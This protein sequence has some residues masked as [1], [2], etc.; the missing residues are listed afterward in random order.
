M[1][2][3]VALLLATV[4][5]VAPLATPDSPH[6]PDVTLS[7]STVTALR[8]LDSVVTANTD[9][10]SISIVNTLTSSVETIEVGREPT[11]VAADANRIWVTVRA[12]NEVV[13]L[14][15]TGGTWQITDRVTVG[16]EPYGIVV[17]PDGMRLY[18]AVSIDD[19]VVEL[20]A[21]T[22]EER[23]RFDVPGEPRWLALHPTG[24]TLAVMPARG[25]GTVLLNNLMDGEPTVFPMD[26]YLEPRRIAMRPSGDPSFNGDGTRLWYPLAELGSPLDTG[27]RSGDGYY[28]LPPWPLVGASLV[29]M[30]F[31]AASGAAT[32]DIDK[33]LSVGTSSVPTHIAAYGDDALYVTFEGLPDVLEF[34]PHDRRQSSQSETGQGP[35]GVAMD[36]QGDVWVH[37]PFDRT[38]TRPWLP[39][40]P[41][42][43]AE[44]VLPERVERGRNLF[45][46]STDTTM[47]A[48]RIS[49]AVCH[50]EGRSDGVTWPL[51]SGD[52]QTP[53]LGGDVDATAPVSWSQD[54]P[55]VREEARLTITGP[56]AGSEEAD[57]D[58]VAA[59]VNHVRLPNP[60]T[61][62]V[63]DEVLAV[64]RAAFETAG[65]HSCHAPPLYTDNQ[66]HQMFGLEAV[67]TPTLFG[68]AS[69]APYLHNGKAASLDDLLD[70]S[71]GH[72]GQPEVLSDEE[73]A[74][75]VAWLRTL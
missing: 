5:C 55:S 34:H 31:S 15:R 19:Q 22:L 12:D 56:M 4:G 27:R 41:I 74:A 42:V 16:S 71:E 14:E 2:V 65:C 67:Q 49:C 36:D 60:P 58:A 25:T 26:A 45:H 52:W 44:P 17:S 63:S 40:T 24:R 51:E 69:S 8:G 39:N 33:W 62:T 28:A 11:R 59:Y 70:R 9:E 72:M 3:S 10:G 35:G 1:K 47:S 57:I 73:R 30:E 50:A 13:V 23:R 75:L 38:I 7:S 29:Y 54:V 48:G 64:G 46:S 18:V 32:L 21:N 43:V 68:I 6:G 37:A 61:R 53:S 66:H 20:D